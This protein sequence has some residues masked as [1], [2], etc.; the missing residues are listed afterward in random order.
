MAG[1]GKARL[2][3]LNETQWDQASLKLGLDGLRALFENPELKL[4]AN[5]MLWGFS[6]A[7]WF[8]SAEVGELS[9]VL[10]GLRKAPLALMPQPFAVAAVRRGVPVEWLQRNWRE[11]GLTWE[12]DTQQSQVTQPPIRE[13]ETE[14]RVYT[15]QNAGV[16]P[17]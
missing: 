9:E 2:E 17:E 4:K 3:G 6:W 7:S 13:A 1:L 15:P 5:I 16:A 11:H 12:Y 10:Q 14:Q 8:D